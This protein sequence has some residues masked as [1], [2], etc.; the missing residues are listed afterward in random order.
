MRSFLI[1]SISGLILNSLS[2]SL[3]C[4]LSCQLHVNRLTDLI[5]A[6][7]EHPRSCDQYSVYAGALARPICMRIPKNLSISSTLA[8]THLLCFYVL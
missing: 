5:S 7:A 8:L 4:M 2:S 1:V 6:I 3:N